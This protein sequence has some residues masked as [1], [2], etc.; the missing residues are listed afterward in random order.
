MYFAKLA[1]T[2]HSQNKAYRKSVHLLHY[3]VDM[4]L[5]A[6]QVVSKHAERCWVALKSHLSQ[7]LSGNNSYA[8]AA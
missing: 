6:S 1:L 7:I 4:D 8:L 3:G 5:T 2:L